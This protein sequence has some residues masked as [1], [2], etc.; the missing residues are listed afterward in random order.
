MQCTRV[1]AEQWM[2]RLVGDLLRNFENQKDRFMVGDGRD[3]AEE[4]K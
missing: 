3:A 4:R 2:P 1:K